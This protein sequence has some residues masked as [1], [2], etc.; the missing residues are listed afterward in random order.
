MSPVFSYKIK[1]KTIFVIRMMP[2][3]WQSAGEPFDY[4]LCVYHYS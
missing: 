1:N 4:V 2:R 3:M